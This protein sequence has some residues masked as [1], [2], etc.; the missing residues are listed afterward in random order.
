MI[1]FDKFI[2]LLSIDIF[3]IKRYMELEI[4]ASGKETIL[5]ACKSLS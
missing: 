2:A 3:L 4:T 1:V 5:I